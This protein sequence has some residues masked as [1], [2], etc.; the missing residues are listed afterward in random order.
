M[1]PYAIRSNRPM[2][3]WENFAYTM[4]GRGMVEGNNNLYMFGQ[5]FILGWSV[6]RIANWWKYTELS[7]DDAMEIHV[8][9]EDNEEQVSMEVG[10]RERSREYVS[11]RAQL[12]NDYTM[13]YV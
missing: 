10:Y 12:P 1:G 3:G 9:N 6:R 4:S 7:T 5:G 13:D 2:E 11:G 8:F